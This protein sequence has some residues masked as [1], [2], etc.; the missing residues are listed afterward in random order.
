MTVKGLSPPWEAWE[1][2]QVS[3]S[4]EHYRESAPG[5]SWLVKVS[6]VKL[7]KEL[8]LQR[9]AGSTGVSQLLKSILTIML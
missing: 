1:N 4:A 7:M 6:L 8:E 3:L 5:S 2:L 9:V